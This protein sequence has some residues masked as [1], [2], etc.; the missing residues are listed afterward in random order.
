VCPVSRGCTAFFAFSLARRCTVRGKPAPSHANQGRE[1]R[2]QDVSALDAGNLLTRTL[3]RRFGPM[4]EA[5]AQ[6]D[7]L[8][9][10]PA[11]TK[12][13]R[14]T[15]ARA[16]YR[17]LLDTLH[18]FAEPVPA[19]H[20]HESHG[21]RHWFSEAVLLWTHFAET[22]SKPLVDTVGETTLADD[23]PLDLPLDASAVARIRSALKAGFGFGDAELGK[24]ERG[25][26][27]L[28]S[29]LALK[30]RLTLA[31]SEHLAKNELL[32]PEGRVRLLQAFY[33]PVPFRPGDV[34]ILLVS[35]A[36]FFFVPRQGAK[37]E[38]ADFDARPQ[39][40]RDQIRDFFEK[41]DVA[42]SAQTKRF[43]SFGLY[44][45]ESLSGTLV[46]T[47]AEA[48]GVNPSVVESTL[49]T[50]FSLIPKRLRAQYLVH[51]LWGHTWQEALSEFEWEYE[52]LPKLDAPLSA[53]DGPIFGG[54]GAPKLAS[55][56][57]SR[58]GRSELDEEALLQFAEA[59]L[60]GR[61][62]IATSVPFSEV[63]ADFM[64][65]KFSR[66]RPALELPTSSLIASTSL[67]IDLTIADTRAQ[68]RRYAEPYRK[69]AVSDAEQA[70]LARE[71]EAMGLP[72]EG[73]SEAV[74][75]AGRA[76]WLAFV[77]AFD[78]TIRPEPSEQ[79]EDAIR[80]SVLRRLL[81]QFVLLMA[82]F[83]RALG[84]TRPQQSAGGASAWKDPGTCPDLFAIAFTHFY[85]QDRQKNFWRIDEVARTEFQAACAKL[86]A[87]LDAE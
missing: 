81:V 12:D 80:S 55:A 43:P 49:A 35:T 82:A 37:L 36:L 6:I 44:E 75:N 24:I 86:R 52:L 51:D 83:E 74:A 38:A 19:E 28:T 8:T 1:D 84:W 62:Q 16:I 71:L 85:E 56:F 72:R 87:G 48:V 31:L 22:G 27:Q 11:L 29:N 41:V 64:E 53:G 77:P 70:R 32:G 73:L 25:I 2:G 33:G 66:A 14:Q 3:H 18:D 45:Q 9:V 23:F 65:S 58:G 54:P 59:D 60:R 63:L 79:R 50:M 67:K 26:E 20:A 57:V 78:E 5:L 4:L 17:A 21:F 76:M 42:N 47:L 61:I 13:E 40:E 46:A 7:T 34:D 15:E 10:G 39:D 68:V 69:L 30:R